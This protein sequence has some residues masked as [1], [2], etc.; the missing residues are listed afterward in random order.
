MTTLLLNEPIPGSSSPAT[1]GRE[2]R[3]A[4]VLHLINGEHY[5][6]A[7]RVQDLLALR[8]PE[9]GFDVGFA[10]VKPGKF[11]EMRQS[12]GT[13]L[14]TFPMRSRIDLTCAWRLGRFIRRAG[15]D[16]LHTHTPR[17]ALIGS[18]AAAIAN[19]PLVHHVHSPTAADSTHRVR[20]WLNAVCERAGLRRAAKA[21]AVSNSMGAYARNQRLTAEQVAVVP[22][23]VPP[24]LLIPR[25][26]PQ[27]TWTLG[28]VALFR[29]RKG[30]EVLLEALA[31]L[32]QQN[33]PVRLRAVGGFETP[34]YE[35][36]ILRQAERLAVV[37]AI[38][39]TGFTRNVSAELARM[40][41][42]VLPSLFGEGLPMVILEAMGAGIPVI[43]TRVEGAPE[44]I[45]DGIDG[46][47]ANPRDPR[48]LAA[49]IGRMV[50]GE[51]DWQSLR[52][53]AHQ[54]QSD[55]FSDRSM[56]AGVA[57]VY[58]ELLRDL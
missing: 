14:Y 30:T 20:N 22:N 57:E 43:A 51:V 52:E 28:T 2:V 37:D 42:F 11:L 24:G 39:W 27:G 48:D 26:T 5:S 49:A 54:R 19:V 18:L 47:I 36:D 21:I 3:T 53:S 46:L 17:T 16:L 34:A 41:L 56:A 10:C 15:Y 12:Q 55:R 9:F 23:G 6:G 4:R 40:D 44:A 13:P 25:V 33:L 29:P 1:T 31:I 7:E 32:K 45:R 38:D 58:R 8:L 35:A 50:R